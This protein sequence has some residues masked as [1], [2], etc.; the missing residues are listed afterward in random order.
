MQQTSISISFAIFLVA[1]AYA[2]ICPD[3]NGMDD[4]IRQAFLK[5]HN[6][7]R[8]L[9]ANGKAEDGKGGYAPSAAKMFKLKYDCDVEKH[10]VKHAAKCVFQ[11]SNDS[12]FGENIYMRWPAYGKVR[13]AKDASRSWFEELAQNGVGKSLKFTKELLNR[14]V[15]HYTQMI[16]QSTKVIGCAVVNCPKMSLVVCN[17]KKAGNILNSKI[18]ETGAPCSKCPGG[19]SEGLCTV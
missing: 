11:H 8:S 15:G 4:D 12:D 17:Y 2:A 18:Y 9:V 19:C 16:W 3:S 6:D 10:A 7:L 14:G 1:S 5:T 13:A